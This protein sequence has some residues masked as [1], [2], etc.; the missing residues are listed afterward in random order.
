MSSAHSIISE[1]HADLA[2]TFRL[3][4]IC[5]G[6]T[7]SQLA[8]GPLCTGLPPWNHEQNP[9][10]E[11]NCL[12]YFVEISARVPAFLLTPENPFFFFFTFQAVM[13]KMI[14]RFSPSKQ[15]KTL[16]TANHKIVMPAPTNFLR[17]NVPLSLLTYRFSL[18]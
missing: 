17:E 4:P 5:L 3:F 13:Y 2:F 7:L 12:A 6:S 10:E 18:I 14:I 11:R 9:P 1:A 16:Y 8:V 15:S